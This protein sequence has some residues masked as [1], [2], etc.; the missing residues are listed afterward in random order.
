MSAR[1]PNDVLTREEMA[2]SY[3]AAYDK[4]RD[5]MKDA[6][7]A[8]QLAGYRGLVDVGFFAPFG[9]PGV[10]TNLRMAIVPLDE[11][12]AAKDPPFGWVRYEVSDAKKINI[13]AARGFDA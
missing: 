9:W 8:A 1:D 4:L 12:D 7:S 5:R 11:Q 13:A 2:A 3:F 10:G 6:L